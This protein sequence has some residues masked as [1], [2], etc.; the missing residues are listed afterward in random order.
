MYLSLIRRM[1]RRGS[2]ENSQLIQF[3]TLSTSETLKWKVRRLFVKYVLGIGRLV[4]QYM[5]VVEIEH[6]GV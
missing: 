6:L 2:F 3:L 4:Q 1:R 5:L